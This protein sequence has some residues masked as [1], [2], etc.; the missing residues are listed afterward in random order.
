MWYRDPWTLWEHLDNF[1]DDTWFGTPPDMW[2]E[3]LISEVHC[4]LDDFCTPSTLFSSNWYIQS[5]YSPES[6]HWPAKD[7]GY[8]SQ[9]LANLTRWRVDNMEQIAIDAMTKTSVGCPSALF[10]SF[11]IIVLNQKSWLQTVSLPS[12]SNLVTLAWKN[13]N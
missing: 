8:N 6:D 9:T 3:T 7:V 10:T 1:K 2:V 11:H 13:Y 4:R 12:R 5:D